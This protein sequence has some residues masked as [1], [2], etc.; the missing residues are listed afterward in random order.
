M[1]KR[2]ISKFIS[3]IFIFA[4]MMVSLHHHDDLQAHTDCQICTIENTLSL[5]DVPLDVFYLCELY[6]VNEAIVSFLDDIIIQ[7]EHYNFTA[8]APPLFS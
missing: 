3:I 4:T 2:L 8:R 6:L 5:A 1:N 7:T